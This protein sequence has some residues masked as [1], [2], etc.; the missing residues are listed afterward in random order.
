MDTALERIVD[1]R[2]DELLLARIE[3]KRAAEET[4]YQVRNAD[5]RHHATNVQPLDC[6]AEG[7]ELVLIHAA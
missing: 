1:H 2:V 7:L 4:V 5:L 3:H 6:F